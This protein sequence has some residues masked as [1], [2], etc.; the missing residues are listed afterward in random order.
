MTT[1]RLVAAFAMIACGADPNALVSSEATSTRPALQFRLQADASYAV[2]DPVVLRFVLENPSEVDL[3]VLTWYTP[4]EG[5]KGEILRVV[6]DGEEVPYEGPMVKRGD[7]VADDYVRLR[8]GESVSAEVDLS[9]GY[10]LSSPGEYEVEFVGR[11]HDVVREGR[12]FPRP[13]DR[14][15]AVD[16]SGPTVTFDVVES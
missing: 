15:R 10:D 4:L 12:P 13:R 5:L 2:G 9:G 6:H 11:V 3:V 7:P 14:H 8:A 16:V 1:I